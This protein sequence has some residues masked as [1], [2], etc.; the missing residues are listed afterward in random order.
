MDRRNITAA[1]AAA[2]ACWLAAT[3]SH[4][5]APCDKMSRQQTLVCEQNTCI[6]PSQRTLCEA[7]GPM[8]E[9]PLAAR[10]VPPPTRDGVSAGEQAR[11]DLS[12]LIASLQ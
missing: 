9:R 1:T 8:V 6:R 2:A 5:G 3:A 7:L 4:A 11:R 10:R 12:L